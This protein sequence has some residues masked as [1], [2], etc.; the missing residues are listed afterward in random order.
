MKTAQTLVIAGLIALFA[1]PSIAQVKDI[2]VNK[3]T[4][5]LKQSAPPQ[6]SNDGMYSAWQVLPGIIP[7]WTKQC[8]GKEM[9]AQQFD[10]DQNAARQT[11]NCIVKR[12]L[13]NQSKANKN[14]LDSVRNVACW[15]MTGNYQGCTQGATATYVNK[16]VSIYQKEGK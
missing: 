3:L 16:V 7:S 10:Q 9:T 14:E 11:V 6:R 1:N 13:N 12:E 15:W 4:E 5:A 2:Q 8:V